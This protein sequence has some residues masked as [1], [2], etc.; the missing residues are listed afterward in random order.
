MNINLC[1]TTNY[2]FV[3]FSEGEFEGRDVFPVADANIILYVFFCIILS[4]VTMLPFQFN[5]IVKT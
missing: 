1:C 4:S 3:D 5:N 2:S